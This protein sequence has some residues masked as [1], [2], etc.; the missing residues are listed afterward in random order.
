MNR[1]AVNFLPLGLWSD[2]HQRVLQ[3][4]TGF[5]N[6]AKR[7]EP[8]AGKIVLSLLTSKNF[9]IFMNSL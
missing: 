7:I 1:A 6:N 9:I 3:I 2:I 4:N 8:T 5:H